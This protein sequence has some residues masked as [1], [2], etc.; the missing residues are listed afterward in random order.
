VCERER[1]RE[2]ERDIHFKIK[3]P[4]IVRSCESFFFFFFYYYYYYYYYYCSFSS[5][6][7]VLIPFPH[8]SSSLS[9]SS[10]SFLAKFIIALKHLQEGH[11]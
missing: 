11:L 4:A 5:F 10:R 6:L 8:F 3:F 7:L 2:V 9:H 1:E